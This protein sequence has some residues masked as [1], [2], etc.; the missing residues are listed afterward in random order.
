MFPAKPVQL[1]HVDSVNIVRR[2]S[3]RY[4]FYYCKLFKKCGE[5][6]FFGA[7]TFYCPFWTIFDCKITGYFSHFIWG[8]GG[9]VKKCGKSPHF[10]FVSRSRGATE[11]GLLKPY[12]K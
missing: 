4:L 8:E 9:A 5:R 6:V 10:L 7:A 12:R 3:K 11:R 1:Y 2:H